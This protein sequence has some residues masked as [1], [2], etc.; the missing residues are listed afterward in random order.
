[1]NRIE[2]SV[3]IA[4]ASLWALVAALLALVLAVLPAEYGIDLTGFGRLTGLIRK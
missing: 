4:R 3:S 1:M 2:S